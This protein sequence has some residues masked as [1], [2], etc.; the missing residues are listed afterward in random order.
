MADNIFHLTKAE[1]MTKTTLKQ[2]AQKVGCHVTAV[3]KVINET[4]GQS[5]VGE[6][7]KKKILTAAEELKYRPSAGARIIR[8]GRSGIIGVIVQ[9]GIAYCAPYTDAME[10]LS[11]TADVLQKRDLMMQLIW[12]GDTEGVVKEKRIFKERLLDGAVVL[13]CSRLTP[14]LLEVIENTFDNVVRLSSNSRSTTNC[15]EIDETTVG[16]LAVEHVISRGYK[17]IAFLSRPGAI[18]YSHRE[19]FESAQETAEKAGIN[20]HRIILPVKNEGMYMKELAPLLTR[21]TAVISVTAR[22]TEDFIYSCSLSNFKPGIDFGFVS[23]SDKLDFVNYSPKLTRI[24][25]D[26]DLY[27]ETAINMLQ[28]KFEQ[29]IQSPQS[30]TVQP[31]LIHGKSTP[32]L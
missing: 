5:V 32:V 21:T 9:K 18:H 8:N 10:L 14:E 13:N 25:Y 3:S 23:A 16:K 15:V 20:F 7:L 28:K 27:L 26:A 19:R 17:R 22:V 24:G 29:K 12:L 31:Y 30:I 4:K 11:R 1:S 6:S 2:I